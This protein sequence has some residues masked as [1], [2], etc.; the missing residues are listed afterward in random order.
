MTAK[1]P[2]KPGPA[3]GPSLFKALRALFRGLGFSVYFSPG[4]GSLEMRV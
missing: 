4:F 2:K 3:S 1:R